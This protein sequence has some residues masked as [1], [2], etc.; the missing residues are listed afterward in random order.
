MAL[1]WQLCVLG[2]AALNP[3]AL[4]ADSLLSTALLGAIM[5]A[6][7]YEDR[8]ELTVDIH[9]FFARVGI[10]FDYRELAWLGFELGTD[11]SLFRLQH[12][13]QLLAFCLANPDYHVVSS[14]APGRLV[15]KYVPDCRSYR[16]AKGDKNPNLVLDPLVNPE[17]A[18][19]DEEV[20]CSA[21]A[22]LNNPDTGDQ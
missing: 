10:V 18:L 15:N 12:L 1:V 17:R 8:V 2:P 19:V 13:P 7:G 11:L 20:I 4:H 9:R 5:S 21:L 6:S 3:A 22:M 14:T 16:L